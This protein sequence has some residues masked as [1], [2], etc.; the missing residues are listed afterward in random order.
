MNAPSSSPQLIHPARARRLLGRPAARALAAAAVACMAVLAAGCSAAARSPHMPAASAQPGATASGA[1]GTR[2]VTAPAAAASPAGPV[3][4]PVPPGF[5]PVSMTFV[6]ASDGWVLGTAPCAVQPCTSIVRTTDGGASWT[7]IPAPPVPLA[8]N[9]PAGLSPGLSYLRF[10]N[11]LDGF[12]FGSQLWATHDGGA[13]WQPVSLPGTIG[14][15]ETAAGVVYAAVSA[16]N[17]TVTIYRSLAAGGAWTAVAGLPA[18]VADPRQAPPISLGRITL[19]GAAAWIILGGRL[20][21]TQTGQSWVQEPV[22]CTPPYA[23][24]STAAYS[25]Q[26]LTL[27]CAGDPAMGTEGRTVYASVNGGASFSLMSTFAGPG[28]QFNLLAEP[29]AQHIFLAT[30]SAATWLDVSGDGGTT[31]NTALTINDGGLG[32]SDFGFTTPTQG[33]AIEGHPGN[34][35][36]GTST[37]YMTLD[38]GQT[39]HQITF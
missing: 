12:A 23:M 28:D 5:E 39:W 24:A 29:T 35:V 30:S 22:T 1:T 25:T 31:W 13:S 7:G 26:Q 33:V 8:S 15:L 37:M 18:G 20:Y 16:Q 10:A 9:G 36:N 38:A 2:A 21:G 19:H 32:W 14:D 3:G 17:G 6:S 4:G 11:S 27:L 34:P